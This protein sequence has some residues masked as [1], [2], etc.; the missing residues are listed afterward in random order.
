MHMI[1]FA[2]KHSKTTC[3]NAFAHMSNTN[4]RSPPQGSAALVSDPVV[5]EGEDAGLAGGG[6]RGRHA[7]GLAHG[8]PGV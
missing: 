1:I 2:D 8:V 4:T 6:A 5:D 7:L 3:L